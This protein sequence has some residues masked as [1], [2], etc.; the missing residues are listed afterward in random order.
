[1][2]AN[3]LNSQTDPKVWRREVGE[4]QALVSWAMNNHW[5][6]NYRAYQEGPVVFRYLFRPHWGY[7]PAG[8]SRFA[9][10]ASQP[11]L[12]VRARGSAPQGESLIRLGS[13]Q[14][15]VTGLKPADDDRGV[16]VRIWNAGEN[17]AAADLQWRGDADVTF[18]RSDTSER[19]GERIEGSVTIPAWGLATVRAEVHARTR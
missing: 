13:E 16:V 7:D 19:M 15:L 2:T 17:E 11:L 4:T 5:G 6:T 10:A 18:Y 3:L 14:L 12:P 1:V 9:V 8:S